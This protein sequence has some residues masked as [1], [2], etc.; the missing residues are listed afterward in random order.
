MTGLER[1]LLQIA[2]FLEEHSVPYMVIGGIAN[3]VWGL[4]RATI[5]VDVTVW[6][7]EDDIP[8]LLSSIADQFKIL[9][10]DPLQF[11]QQTRVLP[12]QVPDGF[13]ADIIFALLPYEQSAIERSVGQVI[14]GVQVQIC[15][16]EDLIIHKIISER[17]QD[18]QDVKGI[19]HQVGSRL[20]RGYLDPFVHGLASDLERPEIWTTT[21]SRGRRKTA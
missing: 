7:A 1:T 18:L 5:D 20:D 11:I 19:V 6:V 15:S 12:V 4:P 21:S 8:G 2:S 16:P 14:H 9:V 10:K 17:P 13:R 3:L